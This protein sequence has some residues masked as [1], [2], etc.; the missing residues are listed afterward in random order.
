M[1]Y[2]PDSLHILLENSFDGVII[3]DQNLQLT[4]INDAAK[5]IFFLENTVA[6]EQPIFEVLPLNPELIPVF[7]Q[8]I[9]GKNI[10]IKQQSFRKSKGHLKTYF[11]FNLSPYPAQAPT[12][13]PQQQQLGVMIVKDISDTIYKT[14]S[15]TKKRLKDALKAFDLGNERLK[16]IIN[17]CDEL[18]LAI[19][20]QFRVTLYNEHFKRYIYQKTGETIHIGVHFLNLF[21]EMPKEQEKIEATWQEVFNGEG[22]IQI[23]YKEL[24]DNEVKYLDANFNLVKNQ[25][26]EILGGSLIARDMTQSVKAQQKLKESEAQKSAL[27]QAFPDAIFQVDFSGNILEINDNSAI[28][29]YPNLKIIGK[30]L[31]QLPLPKKIK[32]RFIQLVQQL[33]NSKD[34]AFYEVEIPFFRQSHLLETRFVKS[35]EDKILGIARD[36][37]Q[38]REEERKI[39]E[40]LKESQKLNENL[41]IKNEMLAQQEEELAQINQYLTEQNRSLEKAKNEL[42]SSQNQLKDTLKTLEERNFELDQFVYKTSHDLRS[43]LSS[44]L[45]IIH[46]LNIEPDAS[47]IPEYIQKIEGRILR[48]DDFIQSMLYYSRNNRAE[49][50]IQV[51]DLKELLEECLED[52]K[53]YKN[54]E[55]IQV[56][57]TITG[58]A[59]AFESDPLRIKIIFANLISNAI[60]YQDFNKNERHIHVHVQVNEEKMQLSIKDNGI[61]IAPEYLQNIYKMFFRATESSEGSGLGLYIVKQTIDKLNGSIKIHSEG[62]GKGLQVMV[63]IPNLKA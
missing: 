19:D 32:T 36:I 55:Q 17:S 60:K 34:T 43:P 25:E 53:F 26:G 27:I 49:V 5:K 48:L 15:I 6:F 56:I 44:V 4:A 7:Q 54:F 51:I 13:T 21:E 18:I 8:V 46:L 22:N 45:G 30:N 40:L 11:K 3:F 2:T 39:K 31:F 12:D 58:A 57:S 16:Y 10:Q 23:M 50:K 14:Q 29:P 37:T 59:D 33:K 63:E 38:R 52:L 9:H 1:F 28:I 47:R 35:G 24:I 41:E 61:G 42:L 62:I 20:T